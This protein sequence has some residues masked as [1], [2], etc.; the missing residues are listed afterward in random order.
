MYTNCPHQLH[1]LYVTYP[2]LPPMPWSPQFHTISKQWMIIEIV[3][4][5]IDLCRENRSMIEKN[6]TPPPHLLGVDCIQDCDVMT[7]FNTYKELCG[8]E[9]M[10]RGMLRQFH[11]NAMEYIFIVN[12][13]NKGR[14][15]V[16]TVYSLSPPTNYTY[17]WHNIIEQSYHLPN[18]MNRASNEPHTC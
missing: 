15:N 8:L 16:T 17:Q 11:I 13:H 4:L 2:S 14:I 6:N 3:S 5:I 7:F 12:S 18:I 10:Q 9:N 1:C